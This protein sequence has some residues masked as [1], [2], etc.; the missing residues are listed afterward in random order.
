MGSGRCAIR[1]CNG[2][3]TPRRH[4]CGCWR[5]A[6]GGARGGAVGC[7]HASG[8]AAADAVPTAE[9][10]R[11]MEVAREAVAMARALH[12]AHR[13]RLLLLLDRPQTVTRRQATADTPRMTSGPHLTRCA[14]KSSRSESRQRRTLVRTSCVPAV[15]TCDHLMAPSL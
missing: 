12:Q 15:L 13:R 3:C 4:T 14:H 5:L 9:R 11:V 10:P 1:R 6:G 8:K 2:R 7:A